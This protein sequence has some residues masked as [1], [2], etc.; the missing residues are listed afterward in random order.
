VGAANYSPKVLILPSNYTSPDLPGLTQT[1]VRQWQIN[2]Q[3]K[4]LLVVVDLKGHKVRMHGSPELANEGI[5]SSYIN[6]ILVPNQFVPSMKKGDLAGA[7]RLTL[8][9]VNSKTGDTTAAT[10]LA[11]SATTKTLTSEKVPAHAASDATA[12]TILVLLI[13]VPVLLIC[14]IVSFLNRVTSGASRSFG[15][16]GSFGG[17]R[18]LG[19]SVNNKNRWNNN[20]NN[21]N[22]NCY[23]NYSDDDDYDNS[24]S[25]SSDSSSSS[26]DSSSDSSSG[27]DGGG[28][29]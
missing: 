26:S 18:P 10:E 7:I 15:G 9:A 13:A 22:N 4:A 23:D 3:G 17:S 21:N 29:W 20:N 2:N 8:T 5:S 24:S 28:S 11:S 12:T 25:S 1:L 6:N 16:N 14:A 19:F 27:S